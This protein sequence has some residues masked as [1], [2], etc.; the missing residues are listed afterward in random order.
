MSTA[1]SCIASSGTRCFVPGNA[2]AVSPTPLA[3]LLKEP[4]KFGVSGFP[5]I[6]QLISKFRANAMQGPVLPSQHGRIGRLQFS[7]CD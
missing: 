6:T 5:F 7:Y 3:P 1:G 4:D 2:H